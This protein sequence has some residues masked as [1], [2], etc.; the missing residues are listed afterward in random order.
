VNR[1]KL[2][3]LPMLEKSPTSP[4]SLR[5]KIGEV[6]VNSTRA[7]AKVEVLNDKTGEYRIVLQGTLDQD[8]TKI[9]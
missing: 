7:V 9:E 6:L 2:S 5:N 1:L 8:E 4:I 3:D